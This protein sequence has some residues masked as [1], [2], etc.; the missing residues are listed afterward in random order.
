MNPISWSRILFNDCPGLASGDIEELLR[1]DALFDR[2]ASALAI[3]APR[4]LY[5]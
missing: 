2:Q 5:H 1:T 3:D 4:F